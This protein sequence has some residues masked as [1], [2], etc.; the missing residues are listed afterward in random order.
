MNTRLS[1]TISL[2]TLAV[3]TSQTYGFGGCVSWPTTVFQPTPNPSTHQI[4]PDYG[5][6]WFK[7]VGN[8]EQV[9]PG[10]APPTLIHQFANGQLNQLPKGKTLAAAQSDYFQKLEQQGFFNPHQPTLIF[11]HGNQAGMTSK[12][13][14][15]DFCYSYTLNNGKILPNINTL[16]HW[17]HWNM[18]IFY[19]TPFADD[20]PGKGLR[21]FIKAITY[22]EMKIYSV[23][24]PA[25]MRWSYLNKK[26]QVQFCIPGKSNCAPL[27]K[28]QSGQTMSVSD[29][30]YQAYANAFPANYHQHIRIA[31]QSLGAQI[32]IQLTNQVIAHSALPK[33]QELILLDPY[34][35]P[36]EHQINVGKDNE[37]VAIYS[38]NTLRRTYLKDPKL[39]L[40]IYRSSRLSQGVLGDTNT[41]LEKVSAYLRIC[42]AYLSDVFKKQVLVTEHLSCAYIY[43]DS[44][45][46]PAPHNFVNANSSPAQIQKLMGTRRYCTINE[47]SKGCQTV[48]D[49]PIHCGLEQGFF[50]IQ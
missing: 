6:Y 34:F 25:G 9:M 13:K 33:P 35:T 17:K 2:L 44:K 1:T 21:N 23:Q 45:Q 11:I 10:F 40:A 41:P 39:S 18:A 42:P 7:S 12:H 36:G 15:I 24:N 31:G 4:A 28:N 43:F 37:P 19:W 47:F 14:R 8:T 22:P 50:K 3:C 38:F 20:V 16:N 32:A 46:F 26:G 29:L 27:P 49:Q 30:A 48:S 5:L